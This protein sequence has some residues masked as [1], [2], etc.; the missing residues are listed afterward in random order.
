MTLLLLAPAP[1]LEPLRADGP[2]LIGA[3][4][5]RAVL[6]FG[7]NYPAPFGIP[8]LNL[9]ASGVDPTLIIRDDLRQIE[10]LGL[11]CVRVLI[12][13]AELMAA[14]GSL[15]E[16]QHLALL[17]YLVAAAA[18][19]GLYLILT[20]ISYARGV[21]PV[22]VNGE[23]VSLRW[24]FGAVGNLLGDPAAR[25]LAAAYLGAL[26]GRRNPYLGTT[27]AAE[28]AVAAW[29][30]LGQAVV[31]SATPNE[32]VSAAIDQ[33][34]GALRAAGVEAPIV[35][36]TGSGSGPRVEAVLA[37]RADG[38]SISAYP[39][40]MGAGIDD[41]ANR[42]PLVETDFGLRRPALAE[43][44]RLAVE[45]D[46]AG[47]TQA[48]LLPAIALA[49]RHGGAA[50]ACHFHWET[51]AGAWLNNEWP[52]HYLHL[53]A[54]PSRAVA[55]AAAARTFADTRPGLPP[56]VWPVDFHGGPLRAEYLP[57]TVRWMDETCL[58]HSNSI[59]E[60]PPDP[61]RIERI[62]GVGSSR[63]V[64]YHGLGAYLLDRLE[65]GL[66]RL[67]V[68]PEADGVGNPF[69]RARWLPPDGLLPCVIPRAAPAVMTCHLPDLPPDF[70]LWWLRGT[71]TGAAPVAVQQAEGSAV[72]VRPGV[73][74]LSASAERPA[75]RR[76]LEADLPLLPPLPCPPLLSA[77]LPPVAERDQPLTLTAQAT[78]GTDLEV[79]LRLIDRRGEH[80]IRGMRPAVALRSTRDVVERRELA[81]R[82]EVFLPALV[83]DSTE[84]RLQWIARDSEGETRY[85]PDG[86]AVVEVGARLPYRLVG[87]GYQAHA[88]ETSGLAAETFDD[89]STG[90]AEPARVGRHIEVARFGQTGA[91]TLRAPLAPTAD[92]TARYDAVRLRAR[93]RPHPTRVRLL[94]VERDGAVWG[95][96]VELGEEYR[97]S[98]IEAREFGY[99]GG[100]RARARI[101][102]T[103]LIEARI[104]CGATLHGAEA[105]GRRS[106]DLDDLAL[107]AGR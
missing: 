98:V 22:R 76:G 49:L 10:L 45:F 84:V 75:T 89:R 56:P 54:T 88:V 83:F 52:S 18:Q 46:S 58:I 77:A 51:G 91:W 17:D 4:S 71:A 36:W 59:G 15:V 50:A 66:W 97:D 20:P 106:V 80:Q 90:G 60:S 1:A 48:H 95:I 81:T 12:H 29:D 82:F 53:A 39:G 86:P 93:G 44:L 2:R 47:T 31:D 34:V 104:E 92:P 41:P 100:G 8:Y 14:D 61:A 26:A 107:V 33:W 68:M 57:D 19:R 55:L 21:D 96:T 63:L 64:D 42:F 6:L 99:L 67:M 3:E 101:D 43:S 27:Y 102:L 65:P 35:F 11:N 24:R 40:G 62:L 13:D 32:A 28:P 73:A 16:N 38:I 7:T 25:D 37:S 94:L 9:Q 70:R 72:V 103:N 78:G 30:L 74:L 23:E 69:D 105:D 79:E 5:G 87:F 85:P